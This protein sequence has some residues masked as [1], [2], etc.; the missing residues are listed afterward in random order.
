MNKTY[1]YIGIGAVLLLIC[2]FVV[3]RYTATGPE[4]KEV[5][6]VEVQERIVYQDRVVTQTVDRIVY[7]QKVKNDVKTET[8]TEIKPDGTTIT[9]VVVVDKSQTD[10]ASSQQTDATKEED[11]V[12][13]VDT[14]ET[15][16]EKH[17]VSFAKAQWKIS[18]RVEGGAFILKPIVPL[19]SVGLQVERRILGPFFAGVS[20]TVDMGVG[21][22]GFTG[23]YS[24]KGGIVFGAE[25]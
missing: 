1:L 11:K 10:S 18:G 6:K 17:E 23:P 24:V 16:S 5:T 19:V 4:I 22:A 20:A 7:V 2:S 14:K 25:F 15:V 3:G 21:L 13:K 9:K 8:E 12:A